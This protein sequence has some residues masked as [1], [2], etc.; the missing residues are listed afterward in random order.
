MKFPILFVSIIKLASL[1]SE[2]N[3]YTKMKSIIFKE[4]RTLY[5]L[6]D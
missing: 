5:W 2:E 3:G 4:M 1:M 6:G